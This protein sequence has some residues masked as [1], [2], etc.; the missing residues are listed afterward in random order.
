ME[1][2]VKECTESI[3]RLKKR[4]DEL[5]LDNIYADNGIIVKASQSSFNKNRIVK[6]PA[7]SPASSSC[8]CI[9]STMDISKEC[10]YKSNCNIPTVECPLHKCRCNINSGSGS[11]GTIISNGYDCLFRIRPSD[12]QNGINLYVVMLHGEIC[13]LKLL[14]KI[15]KAGEQE[16]IDTL[17]FLL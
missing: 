10:P 4:F 12:I 17:L 1:Q 14:F 7:T 8:K 5:G 9:G 11:S 3:K 13:D 15:G 16:I 6:L 2:K